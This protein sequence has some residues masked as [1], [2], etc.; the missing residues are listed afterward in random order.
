M[1]KATS[2]VIRFTAGLLLFVVFAGV[3]ASAKKLTRLYLHLGDRRLSIG[4]YKPTGEPFDSEVSYTMRSDE[5]AEVW[6]QDWNPLV[7]S[8]TTAL[9]SEKTPDYEAAVAFGKALSALLGRFPGRKE[10]RLKAAAT[11]VEDLDLTAFRDAVITVEAQMDS[12]GGL[13][14]LG[15]DPA[16]ISTL[17][18]DARE[19]IA[20]SDA[21]DAGYA[22]AVRIFTK[23][24]Q[25]EGLS[26]QNGV[27]VSCDDPYDVTPIVNA[28]MA[29]AAHALASA[30]RAEA[31]ARYAGQTSVTITDTLAALESLEKKA[32]TAFDSARLAAAEARLN[33]RSS[34]QTI[35]LF[36]TGV[37]A[38]ESHVSDS[39]KTLRAFAKDADEVGPHKI[40]TRAYS[41]DKQTLTLTI[42]AEKKY[43]SFMSRS[44]KSKQQEGL[45][46]VAVVVE[47]YRPVFVRPGIAFVLGL[48]KNP[49][50]STAKSG[51]Q[52]KI[53]ETGAGLARYNVA[54]MLN[55]IPRRWN[56]PTFGGFFQIGVSPKS[57]ETGFYFGTGIQVEKVFTFGGGVML[58]QV[59]RLGGGLTADSL[60]AKPEDMKVEHPFKTAFYL[61]ATVALPG[62]K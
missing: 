58:Q 41:Q 2:R 22:K 13:I 11:V 50:Y 29:A 45:G 9:K 42:T 49:T 15:F 1:F 59:R 8:Y 24:L 37:L 55:I 12:I 5:A 52:F 53:V 30:N 27:T 14:D 38:M 43:Q 48:L 25:G 28:Q 19:F 60:L 61:H 7:W 44:A 46:K 16:N 10:S 57:D 4:E 47:A 26:A 6:V 56:E 20:N 36:L 23:C 17:R 32:K 3:G 35:R 40:D 62:G 31:V 39:L 21:V 33:A 34:G 18:D 51:D 54:A